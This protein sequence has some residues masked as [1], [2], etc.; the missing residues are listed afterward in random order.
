MIIYRHSSWFYLILLLIAIPHSQS[1]Y[2]RG[3][4]W[5]QYTQ[6]PNFSRLKELI[7]VYEAKNLEFGFPSEDDR[8]KA[9]RKELY[10]PDNPLPIDVDV[11]YPREYYLSYKYIL[12]FRDTSKTLLYSR[13]K[14]RGTE[15]IRDNTTLRPRCALL[16]GLSN[17]CGA[18]QWHRAAALSKLRLS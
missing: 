5:S 4:Q 10:I 17:K 7:K 11:Y 2:G 1:A 6:R 12:I 16:L 13:S 3:N 14:W 18:P 15:N 8:Q 9:L